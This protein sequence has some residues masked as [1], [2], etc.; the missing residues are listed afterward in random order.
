MKTPVQVIYQGSAPDRG[1]TAE[2]VTE[3]GQAR[4]GNQAGM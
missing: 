2:R 4:R 1:E 3:A